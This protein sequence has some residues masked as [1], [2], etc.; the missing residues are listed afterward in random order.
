MV[1]P[2]GALDQLGP[3][4]SKLPYSE[5]DFSIRETTKMDQNGPFW[6][7]EV[8]FGAFK[9][10]NR[11]L[12]TPEAC[13]AGVQ[14]SMPQAGFGECLSHNATLSGFMFYDCVSHSTAPQELRASM[15]RVL[16]HS[17]HIAKVGLL[18][19]YQPG[20]ECYEKMPG[21]FQDWVQKKLIIAL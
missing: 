7:G 15:A 14:T 3:K 11:T 6:P 8:H 19:V 10:A 12:A 5:L 9:S 2:K 16:T 21:N 17:F 13:D 20:R 4:W 18:R 1:L